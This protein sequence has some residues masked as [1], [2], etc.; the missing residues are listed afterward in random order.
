VPRP[1]EPKVHVVDDEAAVRDVLRELVESAG[2][3]AALYAS[4][5]EFLAGADQERAGCLV[6][7]ICLGRMSGLDLQQELTAR[8][9]DLPVIIITGHADV[10]SVRRAF[11]QGA[12]DVL[13]KPFDARELRRTLRT[14]LA[15][16]ERLRTIRADR[17]AAVAPRAPSAGHGRRGPG[18]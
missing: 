9:L 15:Q 16:H 1:C 12:L 14:A 11:R 17:S 8:G 6:L 4:A 2:L 10:P 7:D 5:E 3:Q 18:Q 13:Q